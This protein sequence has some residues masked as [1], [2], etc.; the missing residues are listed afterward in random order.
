MNQSFVF[1]LVYKSSQCKE[2][3]YYVGTLGISLVLLP[4]PWE[5]INSHFIGGWQWW[6]GK[7][8]TRQIEIVKY[9]KKQIGQHIYLIIPLF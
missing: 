7:L 3:L 8:R 4:A 6:Q 5:H 1:L 9:A 2:A